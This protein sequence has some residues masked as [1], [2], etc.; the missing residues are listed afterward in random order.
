MKCGDHDELTFEVVSV[1]STMGAAGDRLRHVRS[2]HLLTKP[3]MALMLMFH[4]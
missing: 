3:T 4:F 1:L 2:E